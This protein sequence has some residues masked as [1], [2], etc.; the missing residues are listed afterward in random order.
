MKTKALVML[1]GAAL[2]LAAL[3]WMLTNRSQ[4]AP[5]APAPAGKLFTGAAARIAD[6]ARVVI[7]HGPD[8][9]EVA[10]DA[11]GTWVLPASDNYPAVEDN[12]RNLVRAVLDAEVVEKKTAA[13]DLYDKIGVEDP[14]G[15]KAKSHLVSITDAEGK[16]IAELIIGN[17][18]EAANYDQQK[19]GTFVRP[20]GQAQSYLVK[21]SFN[22]ASKPTDWIKRDVLA[23]D[24]TR[25]WKATIQQPARADGSAAEAIHV[26]RASRAEEKFSLAELPANRELSD[27]TVHQRLLQTLANWTLDDVRKAEGFDLSAAATGTFT[28]FDGVSY[29]TRCVNKDGKFWA[30]VSCTYDPAA[31]APRGAGD[32][33]PADDHDATMKKEVETL[34]ARLAPWVFQ[35]ADH[36]GKELTATLESLLKP[37]QPA[38]QPAGQPQ[39]VSPQDFGQPGSPVGGMMPPG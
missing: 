2:L 24:A 15:E 3:A 17:R 6:T 19:V 18:F 34:Q 9:V 4:P 11:A 31:A 30:T 36:K 20:A 26:E 37:L 28:T 33:A 23:L 25:F 8:K 35:I 27:P 10:R 39:G 13:Q 5:Q 29:T 16:P 22:L 32:P 7:S 1:A 12:V 21:G 38:G 14:A